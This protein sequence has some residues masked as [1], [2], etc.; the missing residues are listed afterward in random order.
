MTDSRTALEIVSRLLEAMEESED[1][2]ELCDHLAN[3]VLSDFN[4]VASY[5][6][7]VES[8]GRITMLGSWGY[9]A[10]RR[11]SED[12]PSLW[13]PMSIT[14]TIRTGQVQ[15]YKNWDVYIEKYPHLVERAGPGKSFVC[16]PFSSKGK[17]SGGLGLT[18]GDELT[19]V[20]EQER[21]WQVVAQ[22]GGL[23]ITK[24]WAAGVFG[25]KKVTDPLDEA[26]IR[27]S[28]NQRD[29]EIIRLTLRGKTI[30]QIA[31]ELQFSDSTIKQ[32]RMAI[33]KKLGVS[34]AAD[35]QHAAAA[36]GLELD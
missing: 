19:G 33:Y 18:F 34:R 16:I 23:F 21:L 1:A 35:L 12:R 25:S 13:E 30:S 5:L 11:R 15:V 22:A 26:E 4:L 6:A 32:A 14:D 24:S 10:H 20:L 28:L 2:N 36:L 3:S 9:P 29:I 7:V 8:D 31:R 27:S 17:R